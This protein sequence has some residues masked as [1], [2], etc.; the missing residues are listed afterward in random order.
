MVSLLLP[1]LTFGTIS[2]QRVSETVSKARFS[3]W[4]YFAVRCFVSLQRSN[5]SGSSDTSDHGFM[6]RR[7]VLLLWES[8]RDIY[9]YLSVQYNW[10]NTQN[11]VHFTC[12]SRL[13][14]SFQCIKCTCCK[15][16]YP[17]LSAAPTRQLEVSDFN[18]S[19]NS[20]LLSKHPVT[21]Q[22]RNYQSSIDEGD[23]ITRSFT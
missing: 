18:A 4:L 1:P 3:I 19:V 20:S 2:Q 5:I 16:Q 9:Y 8:F 14:T 10:Q 12:R 11:I 17:E 23:A 22:G 13:S 21:Q 7:G 15:V 6:C